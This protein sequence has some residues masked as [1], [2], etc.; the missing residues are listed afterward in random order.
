MD[1]I[2]YGG[3]RLLYVGNYLDHKHKYFRYSENKLLD[4]FIP[5]LKKINPEFNRSWINMAYVFKS[6]YSQPIIPLNY[7]KIMP[8]FRTPVDGIYLANLQQTNP[9]DRGTEYAVAIGEKVARLV[10]KSDL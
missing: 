9:Y 5:Y 3:E 6:F 1:K 7:S 4:E 10:L 2:Y 8:D